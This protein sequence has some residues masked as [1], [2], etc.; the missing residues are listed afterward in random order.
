MSKKEMKDFTSNVLHKVMYT[1][2]S[3][4]K[5][6]IQYQNVR[7]AERCTNDV[8]DLLKLGPYQAGYSQ[9]TVPLS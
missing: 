6:G 8:N 9:W 3:F 2:R 1:T 4:T 7:E 5:L